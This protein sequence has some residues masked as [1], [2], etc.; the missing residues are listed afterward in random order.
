MIITK[1]LGAAWTLLCLSQQLI[2]LV[3]SISSLKTTRT[4]DTTTGLNKGRM[5]R[6]Q[7]WIS[8]TMNIVAVLP[9]A[10]VTTSGL[11]SLQRIMC[12][13]SLL[14]KTTKDCAV[15]QTLCSFT[16]IMLYCKN[17][18]VLQRLCCIARIVPYYCRQ[19]CPIHPNL[20]AIRTISLSRPSNYTDPACNL[21]QLAF[22]HQT[23]FAP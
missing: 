20:R 17:C 15:L 10:S 4:N 12:L 5:R 3:Q 6:I 9:W 8:M 7:G 14:P 23:L 13:S 11:Q 18:A 16:K 1:H 19:L 21:A 2:T 22:A